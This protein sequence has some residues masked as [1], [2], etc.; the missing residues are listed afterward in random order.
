MSRS[1]YFQEFCAT[2]MCSVYRSFIILAAAFTMFWVPLAEANNKESATRKAAYYR[3]TMPD[4]RTEVGRQVPSVAVD[5]GYEVLDSRMRLMHKVKPAPSQEE[6]ALKELKSTQQ[7]SDDKLLQIFATSEDAERARDRKIAALDVIVNI[8]KGNI[9][10]LN[11]EYE[12]LAALA[13]SKL[14][15]D[16][17]VPANVKE[18]MDSTERQIQEAEAHIQQKENEKQAIY[19]SYQPDIDRLKELE[20]LQTNGS[21]PNA[22]LSSRSE[23]AN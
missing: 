2:D 6:L 20:A 10:R 7:A 15:R 17:E 18:N 14:R 23:L 16:M 19:D 12:T 11:L 5:A 21:A 8:S 4:G 3:Y 22:E 1:A 9:L 13:A